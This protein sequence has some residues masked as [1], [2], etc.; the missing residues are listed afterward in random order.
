M[1]KQNKKGLKSTERRVGLLGGTFDPIHNGHL[2]MA[3]CAFKQF[4]LDE[5]RF[6]PAHNPPHK[7]ERTLGATD[8]DRLCMVKLAVAGDPRFSVDPI[9]YNR[10]GFSYTKDT[11]KILCD[12]EPKS[13]F[14]FL[15][16]AD[17]LFSLE[18]WKEPEKICRLC[19][20]LVATRDGAGTEQI[21]TKIEEIESRFNASAYMMKMPEIDISSHMIRKLCRSHES[22]QE[23]VPNTVC[24]YIEDHNIYGG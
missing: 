13:K 7:L 20:L 4:S 24:K 2:M 22:I 17:S 1:D 16:G 19:T 18:T 6:I 3:D 12:R 10:E 11:L 9:E 14:F 21:E 5:V 23:Y 8:E 15:I